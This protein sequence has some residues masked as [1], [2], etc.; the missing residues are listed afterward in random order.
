MTKFAITVLAAITLVQ[1]GLSVAGDKSTDS[2]AK[3]NSFV[4][5][6]HTNQ[7]VYGTPIQPAIVGHA[8]TSHQK[9]APKKRSSSA[10]YRDVH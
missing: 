4:P 6:P 3:P 5:H 8:K 10:A 7:H 9:H 2:R 1:P